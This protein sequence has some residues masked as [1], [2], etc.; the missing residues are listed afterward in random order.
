MK[1]TRE[2]LIDLL[3]NNTAKVTFVK[4]DG[5][6]REMLCTLK[7]EIVIPY[8]NKTDVVRTPHLDVLRVWDLEKS[9][10]RGFKIDNVTNV[11]VLV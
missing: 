6:T 7:E 5:S 3:K 10:W 2:Y 1:Y 9:D 11:E 8:V 4:V